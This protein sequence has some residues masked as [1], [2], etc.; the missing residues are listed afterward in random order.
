MQYYKDNDSKRK[1]LDESGVNAREGGLRFGEI[2]LFPVSVNIKVFASR[3]ILIR[4]VSLRLALKR[5][6]V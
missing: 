2:E 4:I 1:C 5:N 3:R 6:K